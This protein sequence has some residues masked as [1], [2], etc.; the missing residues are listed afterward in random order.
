[1]LIG[2]IFSGAALFIAFI[3]GV[4]VGSHQLWMMDGA[5]R[6]RLL[7]GE[8]KVIRAGKAETL[9]KAKEIELDGA[10][11]QALQFQESGHPWLLYPL[12]ESF[13]HDSYLHTVALYRK[14]YSSPTNTLDFG[15]SSDDDKRAMEKHRSEVANRMMQLID[16]Y[17][18]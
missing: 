13:D 3:V 10:I 12:S 6:A 4:H 1:M 5:A 16:H 8:L 18:K 14:D 11:L 9:I 2:A 7:V 15:G 17:G